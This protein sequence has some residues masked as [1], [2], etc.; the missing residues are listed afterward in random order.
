MMR[1]VR[2]AVCSIACV[3]GMLDSARA[4][5]LPAELVSQYVPA[6]ERLADAY[7]HVTLRGK[8]RLSF[9]QAGRERLARTLDFVLEVDGERIRLD[10]TDRVNYTDGQPDG[11]RSAFHRLVTPQHA[12][13]K[14]MG[15]SWNETPDRKREL[16]YIDSITQLGWVQG[17]QRLKS[18]RDEENSI[19]AVEAS[20]QDGRPITSVTCHWQNDIEG[21]TIHTTARYDLSPSECWALRKCVQ[22]SQAGGELSRFSMAIDYSGMRDGVPLLKRV[23]D[24]FASGPNFE[25]RQRR[26]LDIADVE[27]G[28][29]FDAGS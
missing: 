28:L 25:V 17:R 7:D 6:V 18:F 9:P 23:E 3:A 2:L 5:E 10:E 1:S 27:F 26:I 22:T 14:E 12:L 21:M 11:D 4:G 15:Q 29:P 19:D 16:D 13:W 8:Y 24:T 20:V